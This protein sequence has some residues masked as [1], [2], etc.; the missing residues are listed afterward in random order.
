[1]ARTKDLYD[2]ISNTKD[3]ESYKTLVYPQSLFDA[4]ST[5]DTYLL[6]QF[7]RVEGTKFKSAATKNY[8]GKTPN[9]Y[10]ST[11]VYSD[12]TQNRASIMSKNP[13]YI[14]TDEQICLGMPQAGVQSMYGANWMQSQLGLAG[15]FMNDVYDTSEAKNIGEAV[16]IL[17]EKH[18]NVQTAANTMAGA[19]QGIINFRLDDVIELSFAQTENPNVESLFKGMRPRFF[20]MTFRFTPRSKKEQDITNAIIHRFKFHAHAEIGSGEITVQREND[21][22]ETEQKKQTISNGFLKYPSTI[23]LTYMTGGKPN[24]YLPRFSTCAITELN[25]N[26]QPDGAWRAHDKGAPPAIE[27]QISLVELQVLTKDNFTNPNNSF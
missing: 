27:L 4:T 20:N 7:N 21:K 1:M 26:Y 25:V 9:P 18:A 6:I 10:G 11:P 2:K 22:G 23:D 13:T 12:K 14:R 8:K 19:L 24:E 3:A 16:K 5:L 15:R 17:A